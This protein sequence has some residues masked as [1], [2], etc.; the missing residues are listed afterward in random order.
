MSIICTRCGSTNV[1]CEAIVNPNGNV[2]KRYTDESFMYGQCEDCGTYPELTDP[3]EVKMDINR[4]YQEFKSYSDTEPDYAN[5]RIVYKDDGDDLDVK[6]SLKADDKATAM[7]ESI[8]YH[9]DSISDLKSLAEYG[10]EDFILVECFRFDKWTD[11]ELWLRETYRVKVEDVTIEISGKEIRDFY[12]KRYPLDR[13]F[14]EKSGARHAAKCKWLRSQGDLLK[15]NMVPKLLIK[16]NGLG[17]NNSLAFRIQYLF[18]WH[19]EIRREADDS[20]LPYKYVMNAVCLDN[21]QSIDRRYTS[22]D[23]ALL[24]CLNLFNDNTQIPDKYISINDYLSQ[25]KC[26]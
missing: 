19:V 14:L 8:F 25:H 17:H 26:L 24:H 18:Q 1:A 12:G 10:G 4:L 22:F 21:P 20:Y 15:P 9:C 11:E 3:D 2:F 5:C 13:S 23:K 16:G 6:I 7:D